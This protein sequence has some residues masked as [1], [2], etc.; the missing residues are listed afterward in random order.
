M[1]PDHV[2]S[3]CIIPNLIASVTQRNLYLIDAKLLDH[4]CGVSVPFDYLALRLRIAPSAP[5]VSTSIPVD[6]VLLSG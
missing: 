4:V 2:F 6:V 1:L 5:A 3:Y